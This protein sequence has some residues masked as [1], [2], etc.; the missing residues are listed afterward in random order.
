M[1]KNLIG[2]WNSDESDQAT[3]KVLGKVTMTFTEDGKLIYD[4][5]ENNKL[6]RMN[7]I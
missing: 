1:D 4:I 6:Q 3:Q 7:M 2:T 5:F